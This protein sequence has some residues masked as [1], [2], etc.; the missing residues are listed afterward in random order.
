MPITL[1]ENFRAVF[2]LPFY[3]AHALDAYGAEGVDVRLET[4]PSPEATAMALLNQ[5]T[6]VS[7]G[8]PMRVLLTHDR[9]PECGLVAF[10]EVVTRDPF[11]VIGREAQPNFHLQDLLGMKVGTVTEVPTPWLCLQDDLR[12]LNLDPDEMSRVTDRTM[13][14]NET[15]LR[16]GELDAVQVFQPYAER[17]LRDGTGH[18]LYAAASRGPCSYT[19]LYTTWATIEERRDELLR[20]TKAIY[21]M[22]KW[23][24]GQSDEV[25]ADTVASFFEGL[26]REVLIA[27]I[28]R[29][30]DL[31][32]WGK[33]PI[34]PRN[35]FERLR[36][37]CLS[38]GLITRAT[39]YEECV[40]TSL[41]EEAV[42]A[43]PPSM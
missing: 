4:S 29:Y 28:A 34:L 9:L 39:T 24:H 3:A 5:D 27:I 20:M 7:W 8:G 18:L 37:G 43:D 14:E 40:D 30:R 38:G 42:A 16:N 12:R 35:G 11:F 21:R 36:A 22:Q 31:G 15:A 32:I 13:A 17:L 25:V 41:A 6:D 2:Y 23:L 26:P 10:C 1:Y 19:A 33:N